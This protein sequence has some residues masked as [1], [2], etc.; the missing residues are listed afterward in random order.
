MLNHAFLMMVHKSPELFGR[1]VR[2]LAQSN[3]FFFVHI[4]KKTAHFD[5]YKEAVRDVAN[6][7]FIERMSVHHAGVSLIQCELALYRA[8]IAYPAQMDY[9]HL[10]SGQDYPTRSNEQFDA[11]F[12]KH[13]GKS[14]A[15][16]EDEEYHA[17]CMKLKYPLRTDVFHPNGRS[18]FERAFNR[19]TEKIQFK[20]HI[21]RSYTDIWGGWEWRSLHRSCLKSF[22]QYIDDNPQF[23]RRFNYTA[24]GDELYFN[25]YAHKFGDRLKIDGTKPLRY[26]SWRPPYE[27]SDTY[28]PYV[29]DERDF[30]YIMEEENF[31]C[32]KIDLPVSAKLL[33]LIDEHRGDNIKFG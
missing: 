18:I 4:D 2:R 27:R 25:T 20:L 21:R 10:I 22:L 15:A 16:L 3:H 23:I 26:V 11:Y 32:R 8:S 29:M 14:F 17:E 28:R 33:E 6:V 30:P 5:S 7:V 1:I 31:F 12:E 9:F 24:C 13:C 19:L